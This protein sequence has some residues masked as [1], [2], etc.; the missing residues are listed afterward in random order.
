MEGHGDMARPLV[1]PI[2][3][4]TGGGDDRIANHHRRASV[5]QSTAARSRQ[6]RS[7]HRLYEPP[8]HRS[9]SRRPRSRSR[10]S[11]ES[12]RSRRRSHSRSRRRPSSRQPR[13]RSRRRAERCPEQRAD[14]SRSR[15]R[16]TGQRN[17]TQNNTPDPNLNLLVQALKSIVPDPNKI[18]SHNNTVPEFDP[19]RKEQTMT[20]WLHK[21][22]EC[23]TIY[24]WTEQQVIHFALPKLQ[25]VA[26]RWYEGLPS[27]LFSW[28]EWQS[29]LLSAFPSEEN[30]GQ[31]LSDMLAKR[32]R[33]GDS[34]EDYFYDKIALINRCSI[35]GK[36]AVECVLHGIDDRSV[37]LGAEA[38][39]FEDLDKLLTYLR[40]SRNIKQNADR[41]VILKNPGPKNGFDSQT[42]S[43][44]GKERVIRCI[45]CKQLGHLASQCTQPIKKC[46]KCLKIG[47][48]TENCYS[49]LPPTEKSVNRVVNDTKTS[50]K[51]FKTA[52][53]NKISIDS[54]VDLGSECSMIKFSELKRLGIYDMQTDDLPSLRGFGNSLVN[55]L[56]KVKAK[57]VVDGVEADT[58]LLIVPD[59][60][61]QVPLMIG[62]TFTEQPHVVLQKRGDTFAISKTQNEETQSKVK[63]YCQEATKIS[64][65]SIVKVY[66]E[67]KY[68]GDLF[69]D[70]ML[71]NQPGRSH[72]V[73]AGIFNFDKDGCGQIAVNGLNSEPF[74]FSKDFLVARGKIARE[75][76]QKEVFHVE[77]LECR[78][79]REI[80]G[81]SDVKLGNDL[82]QTQI[83]EL[84]LLLNE[85]RKCFAFTTS[86][87]GH[88]TISQMSIDLQ[89]DTPVVYRPYRLAIK[90]KEIVREMVDDLLQNDIVRPST[91]PY[92]S[93]IVLVKKK[94]GNYR[95][96]IDYRALNKITTKENYPMPLIDDQ[97][98]ALAGHTYFTTLDL[99]SGYYQIP[100]RE[101]DKH[102]TAF[103]TP[104]GHFEFNR[105]PF[106]LA[107]APATFQRMM[108]QVLGCLRHKEALAYLDDIIIPS[109]DIAE[110][111]RRLKVVLVLLLES[112]LTLNLSKCV[113]FS[114]SVD[115]LGFQVSQEG[116]MPGA[117]KIEAVERFP[118]PTNQHTVRQFLGLA[119]FFRRFVQGFSIIAKPLTQL[120]RKNASW[121]WGQDQQKA[122]ESLKT[123]LVQKPI[124]ALYNPKADTELHTDAC[125]IGIA[126]ILLQRNEQNLL[127]PVAYFSK[128]TTPEEQ[129]YSSYDLET[130]AVVMS[131][132][133]FRVYL[134][135]AHFKI[136]TD[137]NSLRATF[138]KRDMLPRVARWWNQMQEYDF[139]IE[140]RAG[141]SMAHVDALSR[142]PPRETV[143]KVNNVSETDW[144]VTVQDSDPEIQRIINILNDPNLEDVIDIKAN[145][146]LKNNKLFR[147]TNDG[148][149]WVVPKGVRWQIVKQSHDDLGHFALDK[150]LEKIKSRY[151]FP[152]MRSFIKKY[153][154]SCLECAYSKASGGKQPGFLHPIEK[155]DIPFDTIHIDHVGPFVRSSKGST[156]I[157]VMIDA[158]TRYIYLKPVRNTKTSTTLRVLHEYI[159]IFGVPRR[160]ISDRGTSFTSDSFRAFVVEKGIKHVLNA[161]ATPRANGQVERY[162][163]VIV[164]SL[165]A[166]CIGTLDNKWDDHLLDVQ[167][168]INNTLNKGINRTPAEALFGIRP[169]GL[170]ENRLATALDDDPSIKN[171]NVD[172][173]RSEMSSHIKSLQEAQKSR[174]DKSRCKPHEYK[175]GDLVRVE[176]QVPATGSS[177]KLVPKYQ[178]PYKIT[179]IYEHD[180]YQIEDTPL[181]RKGNK[182]YTTVVAVDKIKPW[183]NFRRPHDTL[184]SDG[185]DET[186]HDE[187]EHD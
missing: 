25:G 53:I 7:P 6:C 153:V 67:P 161:V 46:G 172:E 30:Y 48:E 171:S 91:S 113:F 29:K 120:L 2:L 52:I 23:T 37:R 45:N 138:L 95:L 19:A 164:D 12:R 58:E 81:H 176:R 70:G 8:S 76:L 56:G 165:T 34:L 142:N 148:D 109:T 163:K 143:H 175:E 35:T 170:S 84:L 72:Y 177:K 162:N 102:K 99:A 126:G 135:G 33:F 155:V 110:G 127:R 168:G 15:L 65:I 115:Y 18:G 187:M 63:V 160:I 41:K 159:S 42:R 27:V 88:S 92:A 166:K 11:T 50:D 20:M 147:V 151:W 184:L 77:A 4:S 104:E 24:G 71:R 80:I 55:S 105:M 141:K 167:W 157:L 54:F 90:E 124:L 154:S 62:Q 60:V 36:R 22:N 13:S 125:K 32:A 116:I 101:Q 180:R 78:D 103:V 98:D 89:S 174:Y 73:L 86:E 182:R 130:L 118:V 122:F 132:Q 44:N 66:T 47:H 107:N 59:D 173:I 68:S 49:K 40:N 93:P 146:K 131:L 57:V 94:T 10:S 31:M 129:N 140:Y 158:F 106:G 144:I 79:R 9:R 139:S 183:L 5:R 150:T 136:L 14:R 117:K 51:Y 97:L 43:V 74:G 169:R 39:Q 152:K 114:R 100:I 178:G 145:Y 123:A 38:A 64:G 3:P 112:G 16:S 83:E 111:M 149:R 87:L 179:K 128:Q 185:D 108:H 134:I 69:I 137:C 61:M 119:S 1:S 181:T 21:V 17:T 75:E 28:R 121:V 96:C 26:K 82:E 85:Y 133:K 156:H 186:E